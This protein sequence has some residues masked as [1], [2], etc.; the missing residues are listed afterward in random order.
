[1][2]NLQ[3]SALPAELCR[4]IILY[5]NYFFKLQL[6]KWML[7]EKYQDVLV[8][9]QKEYPASHPVS[10]PASQEHLVSHQEHLVSHPASHQ[11]HPTSHQ[12]HPASHQEHLVSHPASH[13]AI[14]Q[15]DQKKWE[16]KNVN[17]RIY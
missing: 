4:V 14:H 12:E 3:S 16:R 7:I 10:H 1:M 6:I 13:Q 2:Y 15:D 11:E 17:V 9:R 8:S 5:I